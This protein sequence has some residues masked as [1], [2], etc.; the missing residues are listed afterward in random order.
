MTEATVVEKVASG[1]DISLQTTLE[2]NGS[3]STKPGSYDPEAVLPVIESEY[4]LKPARSPPHASLY[5][6]FPF[7]RLF[8]WL[9]RHLSGK[10]RHD[11]AHTRKRKAF[12]EIA[13]SQIPLEILLVL[14]K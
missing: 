10:P 13:E 6:F 7:L 3:A 2:R 4:V 8:R 14:S 5:D 9:W 1:S 11:N 12:A